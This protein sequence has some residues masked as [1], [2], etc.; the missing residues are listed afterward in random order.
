MTARWLKPRGE[1]ERIVVRGNLVL[2]TPAHLGGGD[3]ESPTDMPLLLD[4]LERRAL[5]TGASIAGALRAYLRAWEFG[6]GP[7]EEDPPRSLAAQLFGVVTGEDVSY[8]SP[9]FVEDSLSDTLPEVEIRDG[10]AIDPFTRTAEKK[11]K[12]DVELLVAGTTFPLT[13]ELRVLQERKAELLN[14]LTV[15]LGGLER[16]EISIGKRKRRGYGRCRVEKWEVCCYDLT[17]PEG[18]ISWLAGEESEKKE[19]TAIGQ[20]LGVADS[21]LP[22]DRRRHFTLKATFSLDGSLLIRSEPGEPDAPDMIHLHSKRRGKSEPVPVLSGTSLAGALRARALRIAKTVLSEEKAAELIADMFG[23]RYKDENER[24][25]LK[26]S[27]LLVGETVISEPR[28]LVQSRVKIDRF[29]GGSFPAAL[30]SEQPVFGTVQT[31]VTIELCLLQPKE[32][33]IGLLLLLLK[34]LWT[35]DLPVGGEAGIGRGRLRGFWAKAELVCHGAQNEKWEFV[36]NGGKLSVSGDVERLEAF[37]RALGE[38]EKSE[39]SE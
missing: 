26:A 35:G 33:D 28:E 17:I 8:E 11:K 1:I 20:L 29:T 13:F 37:V 15:A 22:P 2:E 30:F 12:F 3:A 6:Y 9:L 38:E 16:G 10:V 39:I 5:L 24:R 31:K 23:P 36:Q 19:G 18:L 4:P 32:H 25:Q 34:D 21:Q 14:A 27:R 7:P